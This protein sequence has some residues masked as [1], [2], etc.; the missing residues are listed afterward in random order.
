M[1]TAY[2]YSDIE[3]TRLQK[4]LQLRQQGAEPFPQRVERTHTT[5]EAVAAFEAGEKKKTAK[6][7]QAT[8]VGRIRSIRIMGKLAFAHIE[9]GYGR[10]QLFLR[11]DGLGPDRL[12]FFRDY[13]DIGDFVQSSGEMFRTK[14]GEVS[15][16]VSDFRMIAKAI[17]PLPAAKDEEVD[18]EL[19]RHATLSDP[20]TRYRQRYADLVVNPEVRETFRMRAAL[21]RALRQFLDEHDFLEVE[22]PVLQPVYGGAAARP[23]VTHHN[24]LKQE[25]Y[26]RISFE[27]YLKRL[28]VGGFERVYEIGRDFRNEGVDRKHNPEFTML[29]FYMAYADYQ[30]VMDFT[31]EMLRFA[32]KQVLGGTKFTYQG[33][34]I[35]LGVDWPR[36]ELKE[37]VHE[38]AGLDLDQYADAKALAAAMKG[39]EYNAPSGATRGKLIDDLVGA[40]VEPR[41]IQPT[42]LYNYPARFRRWLKAHRMIP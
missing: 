5:A 27:L 18:G 2:E 11:A 17:T 10:V 22:T 30:R 25:L 8:L 7:V 41:L 37:A 36:I 40:Q 6:V 1:T 38:F 9:D 26:L 15:L 12:Q 39:K 14:A 29:E 21:T 23:F 19:V 34:A 4:L 3:E 16:N 33:S 20:E 13:F 32:A 31:E 42:F 35:D 24:Q 28:I